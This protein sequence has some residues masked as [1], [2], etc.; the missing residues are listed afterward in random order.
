MNVRTKAPTP[1][2]KN[3]LDSITTIEKMVLG[4]LSQWVVM[5]GNNK[6]N[7]LLLFFHGG[8]GASMIGA[9][10]KYLSQVR[11]EVYGCTFRL[12]W[13]RKKLSPG[14]CCTNNDD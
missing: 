4:G 9:Q 7:P 8:P 6:N 1:R 12:S 14:Y 3:N 5:R 10:R 2:I 11:R 13:S